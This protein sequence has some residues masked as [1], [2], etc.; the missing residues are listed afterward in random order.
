[1]KAQTLSVSFWVNLF[2]G[3]CV[4]TA[5]DVSLKSPIRQKRDRASS[6]WRSKLARPRT[7]AVVRAQ[8]SIIAGLTD[9]CAIIIGAIAAGLAYNGGVHHVFGV[10][11]AFT[12]FS[13]VVALLFAIFNVLRNE[14]DISA[15]L[16]F[17]GHAKRAALVWN[18]SFLTALVVVFLMKEIAGFSRGSV[19]VAYGLGLL[20]LVC[21]RAL[22]VSWV[23]TNAVIGNVAAVRVVLVGDEA[24]VRDFTTRFTPWM[25]GV[26]IVASFVLRGPETLDDDLALAGASARVLKPDDIYILLPWTETPTI[27]ACLAAFVKVPASLHL[28]PQRV[29]DRFSSASVSR[30]G[31]IYSLHVV[32][33]PLAG[34]DIF[35]K[36]AFDL[37]V[38]IPLLIGLTPLFLAIAVAIWLDSPGPV[39]FLQRRYGFNQETFRIVKFRSM[40]VTED[41]RGVRQA[42]RNDPRVTRVGRFIRRSNI[43]ELP[44]LLNVIRGDM[45]LV[46]PRPHALIHNQHYERSIADYARRH[47]VKP[48]ITG[49]AQIHGLRGEITSEG[50]MRLRV[51]HDLYYI[52]N[53]TMGLDLRVMAMTLLSPKAFSNAF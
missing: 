3:E 35:L 21:G 31:K 41:G 5:E 50:M 10:A 7:G 20:S 36:R 40:R 51:E 27:E 28:G 25:Y 12:E 38:G 15:Y 52:D 47:N 43:D 46:G 24:E 18:I 39:F 48:G 19:V 34:I 2:L 14:Y 44:Q 45:S 53:W 29:L 8:F 6:I 22:L 33:R 30:V 1:M 17:A 23:K 11:T 37:I 49:W 16:T 42:T 26:D 4:V 13:I 9:G 32:R